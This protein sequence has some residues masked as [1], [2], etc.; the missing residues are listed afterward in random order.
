[1][2]YTGAD[3]PVST[4][5]VHEL[6]AEMETLRS[7]LAQST[8]NLS[9]PTSG[10]SSTAASPSRQLST[11]PF[12]H[13]SARPVD[14]DLPASSRH[15]R[16]VSLSMLKARMETG[17]GGGPR[18]VST[19]AMSSLTVDEEEEGGAD[20]AR[21]APPPP[22]AAGALPASNGKPI[23][24]RMVTHQFSDRDGIIWCPCCEGDLIVI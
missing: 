12:D 11:N 6:Q 1:M 5:S 2:P 9:L 14:A 13:L 20:A 17:P 3:V 19:G 15:G 16:K 7:S 8:R 23:G 10:N 24:P 21:P 4:P 22:A 18:K